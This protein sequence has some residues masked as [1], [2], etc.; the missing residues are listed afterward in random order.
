MCKRL[1]ITLSLLLLSFLLLSPVTG[2]A[3]TVSATEQEMRTLLQNSQRR[4]EISEILLTNSTEVQRLLLKSTEEIRLLKQDLAESKALI[5]KLSEELQA[6]TALSK[7]QEDLIART[8]VLFERYSAE[9]KAKNSRLKIERNLLMI[10]AG[11]AVVW[12]ATH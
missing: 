10:V 9:M 3:S 6:A 8:N 11:A 1:K 2:W 12:G 5:K 4:Q 7:N